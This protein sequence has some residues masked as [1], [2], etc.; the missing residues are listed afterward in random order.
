MLWTILFIVIALVIL[1]IEIQVMKRNERKERKLLKAFLQNKKLK[2][3][4]ER[5]KQKI[6]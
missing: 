6:V 4:H 3:L 1:V 5:N 2:G